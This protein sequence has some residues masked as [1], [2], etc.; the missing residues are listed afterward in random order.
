M[1]HLLILTSLLCLHSI[2]ATCQEGRSI[3]ASYQYSSGQFVQGD[4]IEINKSKLKYL[5]DSVTIIM[6]ACTSYIKEFAADTVEYYFDCSNNFNYKVLRS[7][8]L[9]FREI[10][11]SYDD[12]TGIDPRLLELPVDTINGL[13]SVKRTFENDFYSITIY[14]AINKHLSTY[15]NSIL[16]QHLVLNEQLLPKLKNSLMTRIIISSDYGSI[17]LDLYDFQEQFSN[18]SFP[19]LPPHVMTRELKKRNKRV[20]VNE[21]FQIQTTKR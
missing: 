19:P 15:I 20:K 1:R 8:K 12:S 9:L 11:E 7:K 5:P 16:L 10:T 17:S 21:A 18:I 2:N 14:V 6:N 13:A 3:R 4:T